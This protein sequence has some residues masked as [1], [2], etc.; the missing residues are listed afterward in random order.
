MTRKSS[1]KPSEGAMPQQKLATV[2][3]TMHMTK[4][5]RRPI[6]LDAQPPSGSTMAFETR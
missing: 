4:K 5:L 3:I 6:T 2:K 1:S